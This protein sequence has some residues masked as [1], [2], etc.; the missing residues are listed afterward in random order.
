[1]SHLRI[2][3]LI[4]FTTTLCAAQSTPLIDYHQHLLSPDVAKLIGESRTFAASDLIAE[5]DRAGLRKAVVLSLAYQFGNPNRPP[6]QDEYARV[7]AEND[8]TAEQVKQYPQRL[9]GVCGVDPLREYA[10]AEIERCAADPYLRTGIK[11]H[12]GNSD[13]DLDNPAHVAMLR[14]AFQTADRH[15]MAIIVHMHANVTHHRPYGKKEA[16]AFLN[17]LLPAAP[18][19]VVQIA[20]LAGSGGWD[21]PASD[22]ALSVFLLAMAQHDRR[23]AH[24]YFDISGVAGLGDAWE[25]NKEEIALRI[26]QVGVRRVLFGSDGAWTGFTPVKAIAAYRQLPLTKDEMSVIDNNLAPYMKASKGH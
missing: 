26:R 25:G 12:F 6:V 15:R 20:H 8:W 17:Q 11:L 13:V 3:L 22:E 14:K 21:D 18:H 19:S 1:M 10:M 16:E 23:V 4:F 9:V 5:M 24:I 7:K 2:V